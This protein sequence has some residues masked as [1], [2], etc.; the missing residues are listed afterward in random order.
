ML[1]TFF[2][3]FH[4][5]ALFMLHLFACRFML[6]SLHVAFFLCC[7]HF[8][9]EF[10][11][12]SSFH[13]VL[14][15]NCIFFML[16]PVHVAPFCVLHCSQVIPFLVLLHVA[17]FFCCNFF[18]LHFFQVSLFSCCSFHCCTFFILRSF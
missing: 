10:I 1:V 17:P 16:H 9:F 13:M 5:C 14:F 6:L 11:R 15:S 18:I 12:V 4:S 7:T 8:V 3:I 2:F